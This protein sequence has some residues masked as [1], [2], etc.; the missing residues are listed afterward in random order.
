MDSD[1]TGESDDLIEMQ[2]LPSLR[3]PLLSRMMSN[4]LLT[5]GEEEDTNRPNL[6][7]SNASLAGG[8]V[9]SN[10]SLLGG[11]DGSSTDR[12]STDRSSTARPML[13]DTTSSNFI[14]IENPPSRL[15]G[16][17]D[18]SEILNGDFSIERN[19]LFPSL[20]PTCPVANS[21]SLKKIVDD[22]LKSIEK[23]NG[24]KLNYFLKDIELM[25]NIESNDKTFTLKNLMIKKK[26]LGSFNNPSYTITL[27][28]TVKHLQNI[29]SYKV[30][31]DFK[32]VHK[33]FETVLETIWQTTV[34]KE[35]VQISK[36]GLCDGC[37]AVKNSW[38]YGVAVGH[39][40]YFPVCTICFE[41]VFSSHL[42]CS[43]YFH[44]S[45]IIEY[46]KKTER[47]KLQCPNCRLD[48][49][50]FD[51]LNFYIE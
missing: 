50:N 46:S 15:L 44:K 21:P 35:C 16:N 41:P 42:E 4:N 27:S 29:F 49:T 12:S 8:S 38:E 45:C 26:R 24:V 34:C 28:Y 9:N 18:I 6:D 25:L 47:N 36:D 51:K 3:F 14:D 13:E 2:S 30:K 48:F 1:V 23:A 43:H 7:N 31:K 40:Q 32:T 17:I 33:I 39:A 11:T 19:P 10:A 5:N 22:F 20:Q 37:N